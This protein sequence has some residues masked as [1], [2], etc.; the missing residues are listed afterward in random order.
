MLE[1]AIR[2]H[3]AGLR[4]DWK[5]M[6]WYVKGKSVSKRLTAGVDVHDFIES[7]KPDKAKHPWAQSSEEADYLIRKLT[8]N[9]HS[10][11]V[12]PFFGFGCICNSSH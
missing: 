9:E 12:D 3:A 4:V 10:L 6:L 5:P 11:V 2:F 1:R 7:N 8:V